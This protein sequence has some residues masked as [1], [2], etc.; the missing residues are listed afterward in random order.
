MDLLDKGGAFNLDVRWVAEREVIS[1]KLLEQAVLIGGFAGNGGEIVGRD[2]PGSDTPTP[3]TT[4]PAAPI[5]G[6][7]LVQ[8]FPV[9]CCWPA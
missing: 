9:R 5:Q 2:E 8:F 7:Q 1:L 6:S 3:A 4:P